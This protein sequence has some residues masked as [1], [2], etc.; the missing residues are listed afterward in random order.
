M[1]LNLGTLCLFNGIKHILHSMSVMM[2]GQLEKAS[3][4]TMTLYY[5]QI[6]VS[7]WVNQGVG[8]GSKVLVV[9]PNQSGSLVKVDSRQSW[10]YASRLL[11]A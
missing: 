10:E 5:Q 1:A 9:E 7:T 6:K 3:N 8:T 11:G 2:K 4:N